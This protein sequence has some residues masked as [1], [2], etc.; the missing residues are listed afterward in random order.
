MSVRK[1]LEEAVGEATSTE[2]RI[3]R[4]LLGDYPLAGL[5]TV[6]E[7]GRASD[8]SGP[9]VVRLVQRLGFDSHGDFQQRLRDE[10]RL[11]LADGPQAESVA[12]ERPVPDS[13]LAAS[14]SKTLADL[15]DD[16]FDQV[17]AL[18]AERRRIVCGGGQFSQVLAVYLAAHL[19]LLRPN[20]V[21]LE[22]GAGAATGIVDLRSSD[23]VVL[24]DYQP[25]ERRASAFANAI[26]K[27]RATLVAVTDP[28]LSPLVDHADHTIVTQVAFVNG[29]D[30]LAPAVAA[31]EALIIEVERRLG[32]TVRDRVAQIEQLRGAR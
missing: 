17:A 20:V 31:V 4:Y 21:V 14:I 29:F 25:H 19:R 27:R 16:A 6:A 15:H 11:L 28:F 32:N 18:L 23:V 1:I 22:P 5:E 3:L 12:S 24:F 30:S 10:L 13:P 2:R 7:I 9:T 26:K 8:T